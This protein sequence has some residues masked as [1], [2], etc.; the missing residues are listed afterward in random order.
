MKNA[1]EIPICDLLELYEDITLKEFVDYVFD[2]DV[3]LNDI[4]TIELQKKHYKAAK[5]KYGIDLEK[6]SKEDVIKALLEYDLK[7][8]ENDLNS[9]SYLKETIIE[10]IHEVKSC[11]SDDWISDIYI[12]NDDIFVKN[13]SHLEDFDSL[14][15]EIYILKNGVLFKTD[16]IITKEKYYS[17][18]K[19][20][21]KLDY[22]KLKKSKK[23]GIKKGIN[24]KKF[25]EEKLEEI[26]YEVRCDGITSLESV[27]DY[28]IEF[29]NETRDTTLLENLDEIDWSKVINYIK[30]DTNIEE[31]KAA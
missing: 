9:S 18:T 20:Y 29:Y 5:K 2:F 4:T 31:V 22:R 7:I 15:K 1:I 17:L 13:N 25:Y 26:E 12:G 6:Y 14:D 28:E 30:K 27:V 24:R 23:E 21:F 10:R 19:I 3:Y 16:E 8:F 11:I